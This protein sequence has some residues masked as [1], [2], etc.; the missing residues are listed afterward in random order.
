VFAPI[1]RVDAHKGH[2]TS[3]QFS[4]LEAGNLL[5]TASN[6]H[7]VKVWRVTSGLTGVGLAEVWASG[8]QASGGHS[9]SVSALGWGRGGV[10]T[11]Q[12]LFS[13]SWDMSVKVWSGVTPKKVT[14][15]D[16]KDISLESSIA[17]EI[18][19]LRTLL[20]H[21]A[22]V[23][24]VAVAPAGDVLVSVSADQTARLWRLRDSFSCIATYFASPSDGVFSSVSIGSHVFVTGSDAGMQ[25]WPLRPNGP[26]ATRFSVNENGSISSETGS[27]LRT[28]STSGE[29]ELA[30][31]NRTPLLSNIK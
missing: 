30:H 1:A 7:Q 19:P 18:S 26:F 2:V 28:A 14:H 23:T 4:S 17:G 15:R 13:G 12:L 3:L 29:T 16:Y 5:A 20:G 8:S 25:V 6:D 21:A 24:G 9:S 31:S 22:R 10:D 27:V 11:S